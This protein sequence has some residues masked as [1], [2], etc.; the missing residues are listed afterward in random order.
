MKVKVS[1]S[2]V[3]KYYPNILSIGY[4]GAE[5][6]L[7]GKEPNYYTCGEYG[8]NADIYEIDKTTVIVTGYRPFGKSVDFELLEDYERKAD[9]IYCDKGMDYMQKLKKIDRLLKRWIADEFE[10]RCNNDEA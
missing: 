6:L 1:Q 7:Y 3:K 2:Q 5:S 4:C 9:H 10:R 8:W